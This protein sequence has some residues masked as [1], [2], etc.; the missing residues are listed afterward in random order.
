NGQQIEVGRDVSILTAARANGIYIPALCF[1]PDL[2]FVKMVPDDKVY[3]GTRMVAN[4]G[5]DEEPDPCGLCIVRVE[6]REEPVRACATKVEDGMSVVTD[7]EDLVARRRD[8]LKHILGVSNHPTICITCDRRPRCEPFG[9]CVRSANVSKRCVAC[10]E[11]PRCELLRVADSVGLI[12]VT[13]PYNDQGAEGTVDNILFE[14]DPSLCVGCLRCVRM[15]AYVRGVGAL[16]FVIHEGRVIVGTKEEDFPK[17][18]CRYCMGCVEVCPT[19]AFI[20][21]R[22]K[23]SSVLSKGEK[24]KE[25]VPCRNACPLGIDV[26]LYVYLISQKR[27]EEAFQV[28]RRKLPFPMLCG[29]VCTR[30]CEESCR[31]KE[32][33]E[34]IAIRDLKRFVAE[35]CRYM[36][37]RF[38]ARVDS[39]KTVAVIGSGPAGLT[40]AY[41]L[42][43]FGGY[44]VTVYEAMSEPGGMPMRAIPRFRLPRKVIDAEVKQVTAMGVSIKT[45]TRVEA[46]RDLLGQGFHAVLIATGCHQQIPLGIEGE[47][48]C[49]GVLG[50]VNFLE[51]V[52]TGMAP[53][54][55]EKSVVVIGGGNAAIDAA[56]TCIRLGAS[57]VKI[58]YR[59][60]E[61]YMTADRY[62]VRAAQQEGVRFLFQVVPC[63]VTSDGCGVALKC[64][65]TR[66]LGKDRTGRPRP[67]VVKGSEFTME[68]DLV[69][70]AVGEKPT[71]P[72]DMRGYANRKGFLAVDSESFMTGMEGVFAVGDVVT[73]PSSIIS[74]IAMGKKAARSIDIYLGGDGTVEESP[75]S[76]LMIPPRLDNTEMFFGP[77]LRLSFNKGQGN[78]GSVEQRYTEDLAV[79]EARRCLRCSLRADISH[80]S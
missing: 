15:C 19:G 4:D 13:L 31:R 78:L 56:R 39:G 59:R 60:S 79:M 38:V 8:R 33:D 52:N 54:L 6:G 41:L 70:A 24:A 69:I 18:G 50:A 9:V 44:S 48:S 28:I 46:V 58:I 37:E 5:R 43:R 53:E 25:L 65:E 36:E 61:E 30:P 73:G 42:A 26:P 57:D 80:W 3:Q 74:A 22:E 21:K 47:D 55:K 7:D 11:Y 17:S 64:A 71:M 32:L 49:S 2:P 76:E 12:G 40:A 35:Q 62:E 1:H 14:F 23:W 63:G 66:L 16:G 75:R 68:T 51:M 20:D 29:M 34:P 27:Y 77:R 10:A 67:F 72:G 45:N